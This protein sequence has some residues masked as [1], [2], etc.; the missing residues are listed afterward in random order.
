MTEV[1]QKHLAIVIPYYKNRYVAETLRSIACQT[2]QNFTLYIGDDNSPNDIQPILADLT[3][4]FKKNIIF[5]RF[6][7]NLGKTLLTKQWERCIA[8]TKHEP[9]IW[10]FGDDDIMPPD[11]VER[12]YSF[13]EKHGPKD[14]IRFN[15]QIVNDRG[16]VIRP[17]SPH[18]A[19]ETAHEYLRRRVSGN[20][21]STAVEFVFKRDVYIKKQGFVELPLAWTADDATWAEFAEDDGI[22][23]ISG[24]PISWRMGGYNISSDSKKTYK[25]KIQASI[26]FFKFFEDKYQFSDSMKMRMLYG[27]LGLLGDS[28]KIRCFFYTQIYR[29]GLFSNAFLLSQ[30]MQRNKRFLDRVVSKLK[31]MAIGQN[32]Q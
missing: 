7:D 26:Q 11:A 12:F 1:V 6:D 8:L 20:C 9:Y 29:S 2:N 28:L 22:Y 27:Q 23:T 4:E 14:V 5:Y 15:L 21:M 17:A 13:V 18:P 24:A 19:F 32:Q 31:R 25:K 10:L 16:D 30:I 3:P